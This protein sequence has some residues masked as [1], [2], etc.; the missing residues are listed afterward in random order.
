MK[1]LLLWGALISLAVTPAFAV[2]DARSELRE[3]IQ[4]TPELR[5][6]FGDSAVNAVSPVRAD[7]SATVGNTRQAVVLF[8]STLKFGAGEMFCHAALGG[9]ERLAWLSQLGGLPNSDSRVAEML[10][11]ERAVTS[12]MRH[13]EYHS[14]KSP[15]GWESGVCRVKLSD[16][17]STYPPL[18]DQTLVRATTY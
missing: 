6:V 18:P 12:T 2:A 4:G 3:F 15:V 17:N 8:E 5:A 7:S 11:A 16:L 1:R 13:V 10:A 14:L 9:I